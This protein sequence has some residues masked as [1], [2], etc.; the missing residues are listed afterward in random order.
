[1]QIQFF[2]FCCLSKIN[3]QITLNWLDLIRL[4]QS[5]LIH[6]SRCFVISTKF[7]NLKPFRLQTKSDYKRTRALFNNIQ[8]TRNSLTKNVEWRNNITQNSTSHGWYI[9]FT[10]YIN[11]SGSLFEFP[12]SL[13]FV[14]LHNFKNKETRTFA[15]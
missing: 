4:R 7:L 9:D 5:S 6:P 15:C 13:F 11:E 3:Y 10:L 12:F 1:M 2:L 14:F 8:N